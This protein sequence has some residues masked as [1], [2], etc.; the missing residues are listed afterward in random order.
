MNPEICGSRYSDGQ[1]SG[2]DAGGHMNASPLTYE[3]GTPG[4]RSYRYKAIST[5]SRSLALLQLNRCP[6][7]NV[8]PA[9]RDQREEKRPSDTRVMFD[10]QIVSIREN[11]LAATTRASKAA[12]SVMGA[13]FSDGA[14]ANMLGLRLYHG[15]LKALGSNVRTEVTENLVVAAKRTAKKATFRKSHLRAPSVRV[16]MRLTIRDSRASAR[17]KTLL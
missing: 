4:I 5:P 14:E 10:A 6:R 3:L 1:D 11:V 8:R 17:V 2:T 16:R 7:A 13:S 15:T 9:A 12:K